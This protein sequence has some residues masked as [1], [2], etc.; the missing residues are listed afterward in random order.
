MSS[1]E[2]DRWSPARNPY[3]IA[4]SQSWW[5]MSA[6]VQFA[7][8]AMAADGPAQQIYARQIFGHLRLL[9]RCAVM[10]AKE[11]DR[12]DIDQVHRDRLRDEIVRFEK[13]VPAA[14]NARDL[15]EHFDEYARGAGRLQR[16][17]MTDLGVDVLEAAAMF[18]GGGYDAAADELTEGPFVVVVSHAVGA[19]RCLHAAIY[20]AAQAVDASRS[21][22]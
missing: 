12:L 9:Q 10:L 22:A 11:L 3:A 19:S 8:D 13:A 15:L 14:K 16:M 2:D 7:A 21:S 1:Q 20:Q 5:A 4:V 6:V 18:W 17:A